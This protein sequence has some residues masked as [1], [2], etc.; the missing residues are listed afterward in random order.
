M[1]FQDDPNNQIIKLKQEKSKNKIVNNL[2][3]E[4]RKTR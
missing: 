4:E 2:F 1:Y 3:P